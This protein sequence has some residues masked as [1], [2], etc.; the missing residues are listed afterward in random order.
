MG[1]LQLTGAMSEKEGGKGGRQ[2]KAAD[3][4]SITLISH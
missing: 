4:K 1:R 3:K 2:E